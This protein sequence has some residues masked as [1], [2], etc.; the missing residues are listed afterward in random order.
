MHIL[1]TGQEFSFLTGNQVTAVCWIIGFE[2]QLLHFLAQTT[3]ANLQVK[4]LV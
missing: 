3:T 1:A 2:D 4:M